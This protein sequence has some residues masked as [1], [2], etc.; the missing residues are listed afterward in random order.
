MAETQIV[1]AREEHRYYPY[2]GIFFVTRRSFWQAGQ[3]SFTLPPAQNPDMFSRLT[4]IEPVLQGILRRRRGYRLFSN[5]APAEPY[6]LGY[7]FRND[8]Q[9]IRDVVFTSTSNVLATDEAGNVIANPLFVPSAG[10]IAP[11]MVLSRN[12]GYFTDAVPADNQKWDGLSLTKWGID[13]NSANAVIGPNSPSSGTTSGSPAWTLPGNIFSK[14]GL[15]STCS[16]APALN[17]TTGFLIAKG[18]GFALGGGTN[19]SEIIVEIFVN[20]ISTT[21]TAAATVQFSGQ[22]LKAGLPAGNIVNGNPGL[23]GV[24]NQYTPIT[25]GANGLWGTTWT[26][27]DLGDANFGVRLTAN[28]TQT[29]FPGHTTLGTVTVNVDHV[30]ITVTTQ[31]SPVTVAVGAAGNITLL[32]G[33]TYFYAFQ[34]SQ[35]GAT[36]DISPASLS[37]GPVS[38]KQINIGAIPTSTDPQVDTVLLLATADGG[39]ETTLY[40]VTVLPI[41]TTTYVDNTPDGLT[42]AVPS[43]ASL[44]TNPLY[45]YTDA[46]GNLH[47]IANNAPP[48]TLQFPTKHKG[49]I[50]GSNGS[51]LYFSKNLD[52]VT[53]ADGLITSK[54]EEAFPASYSLDISETAETIKGILSDGETLWIG[55]ERSIRRLIGDSPQN[56]QKPEVQFNETGLLN[57]DVWKIVFY[58]GQ[59]VGTMWLTPDLRVISSDFNTYRDVGTAIQDILNSVNLGADVVAHASFVS[60][61][62]ADYY[63]LYLATGTN[64]SPD[65]VAVYNLRTQKWFIWRPQDQITASTF[66]I[67]AGGN[68]RWL[69]AANIGAGFPPA[70]GSI[71]EWRDGTFVDRGDVSDQN[72][73]ASVQTSWL[74]FGD[75]NLRK[76][77]N[78]LLYL[79]NSFPQV[80]I[81]GAITDADLDSTFPFLVQPATTVASGPLEDLF[82]PLAQAPSRHRWYRFTYD[83]PSDQEPDLLDGFSV[84]SVGLFRY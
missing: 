43:G 32:S 51:T 68:P 83:F 72:F 1:A 46:F 12:F 9:S 38:S 40:Q 76:A 55:T 58:E 39:D 3:D 35:T 33:R 27:T 34:N 37:T 26:S 14:N 56:F 36:S 49:R 59:P 16:T 11:R 7:S 67:D 57:Q 82:L 74:D 5:Q 42:A 19:V 13:I 53:T 60:K 45:Q 54:W 75:S 63:M 28:V 79:G 73:S 62:P 80:T 15:V 52:D 64:T 25:G 50:Y 30:R 29:P 78:Q 70:T 71:Y 65:T 20:S 10:A 44:L 61:G 22:L 24:I 4:N 23:N 2:Q 81:E 31:A 8:L 18:F 69:F 47:G 6:I 84:E 17:A 48:A 77:L 66:F 21:G 41:G